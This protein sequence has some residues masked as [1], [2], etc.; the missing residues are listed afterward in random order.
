MGSCNDVLDVGILAIPTLPPL[1]Q[2]M[3]QGDIQSGVAGWQPR[4]V[5]S[6]YSPYT[7][8]DY[9]PAH[10]MGF[11]DTN[12]ADPWFI[13]SMQGFQHDPRHPFQE[14]VYADPRYVVKDGETESHVGHAFV[15]KWNDGHGICGRTIN[16]ARTGEHML[17]YHFKSPL[18]AG[19]RL[20]C[21]WEGCELH[22]L[23]R[24]DTIIRHIVEIHLGL[25]TRCKPWVASHAGT[26][27]CGS[28]KNARLHQ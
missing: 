24:R 14:E 16:A 17:S 1:N 21:L 27:S 5:S 10:S 22:K 3:A 8:S 6:S 7:F 23:V 26:S 28:R 12:L 13:S 19:S 20:G 11:S 2:E 15:C 4:R 18:P 25:K 9:L